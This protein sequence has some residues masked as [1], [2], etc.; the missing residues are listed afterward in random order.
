MTDAVHLRI[1]YMYLM[2]LHL[3]I[4]K[5]SAACWDW[6]RLSLLGQSRIEQQWK[7]VK[8]MQLIKLGWLNSVILWFNYSAIIQSCFLLFWFEQMQAL[9]NAKKVE[10]ARGENL[11]R[12]DNYWTLF[13]LYVSQRGL[14]LKIPLMNDCEITL[15]MWLL[16]HCKSEWLSVTMN[17]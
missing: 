9:R 8:F 4:S 12:E 6:H 2:S 5:L 7:H 17:G 13:I 16:W 15:V 1:R 10:M 11:K 3:G 14:F